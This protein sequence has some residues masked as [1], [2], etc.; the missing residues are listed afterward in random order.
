[1]GSMVVIF[2]GM[3]LTSL[4]LNNMAGLQKYAAP[5]RVGLKKIA[6]LL[7]WMGVL[8]W[9]LLFFRYEFVVFLSR[10]LMFGLWF[11]GLLVWATFIVRY[12]VATAPRNRQA[13]KEQERLK[14][15]LP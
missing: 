12:F 7:A 2:A 4:V 8:A 14:K 15:Y 11:I 1:L 6:R 9:V 3:I 10:R 13:I 5:L